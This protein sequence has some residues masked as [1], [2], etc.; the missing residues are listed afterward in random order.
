MKRTLAIVVGSF[1]VGALLW[2]LFFRSSDEEAVRA[3]IAK[4]AAAV[5]VI[6]GENPVLRGA[7]IKGEFDDVLAKD[8]AVSIP[9]LTEVT[10]GREPL[11]GVA[12]QAASVYEKAEVGVSMSH[13]QLDDAKTSA[14][15]DATAT[16][17]A[18]RA[19]T[20]ERDVRKV[21]FALKKTNDGWRITEITVWPRS[22]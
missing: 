16:L 15:V 7:R 13:V 8:V 22:D 11:V 18:V 10:R 9:E 1:A 17:S 19:G 14:T 2:F 5:K 12:V 3:A 4:L 20:S 21:A 6:P